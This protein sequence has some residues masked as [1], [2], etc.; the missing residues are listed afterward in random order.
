MKKQST[1]VQTIEIGNVNR[2][3]SLDEMFTRQ[4]IKNCFRPMTEQEFGKYNN[5]LKEKIAPVWRSDF[6][7][8]TKTIK[9]VITISY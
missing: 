2:F 1:E 6:A 7:I 8:C 5:M 9:R 4:T 3:Q